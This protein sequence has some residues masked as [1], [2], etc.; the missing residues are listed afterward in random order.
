MQEQANYAKQLNKPILLE[1]FGVPQNT[2]PFG[3]DPLAMMKLLRSATE[4]D[5]Y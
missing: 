4:Q 3:K 2:K 5:G 1:E